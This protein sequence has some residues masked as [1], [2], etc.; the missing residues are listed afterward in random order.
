[1]IIHHRHTV[2]LAIQKQ[3][4]HFINA[5]L[6]YILYNLSHRFKSGM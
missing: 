1:M 3:P 5:Y 4:R 2:N 6:T